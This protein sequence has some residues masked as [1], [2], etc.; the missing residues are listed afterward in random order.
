[1][2]AVLDFT[3]FTFSAE[4]IRAVNELVFD[5]VLKSPD[6]QSILTFYPGIVYDKEIGFIGRGGLVG[7]AAEGCDPAAQA[8]AIS[9]RKVKWT[10]KQWAIRIEQCAKDLESTA[11]VYAMKLGVMYDDFTSSDYMNIVIEV[12]SQSMKEFIVRFAF[13]NDTDADTFAN[14]G[15]L[16]NGIDIEYFTINDG[17]FKQA[18]TQVTANAA[19]RVTI[20]ENAGAN[21][22][23]QKLT[24][25]NVKDVY[26]PALVDGADDR[27]TQLANRAILCTNSFYKAYKASLRGIE[28]ESSF[29]LLQNGTKTLTFD[30]ELLIPIPIWDDIISSYYNNGTKKVNP[31]R[32]LYTS[33]DLLALG[34]DTESSFSD[35]DVFY[36][37]KSKK[38]IIDAEGKADAKILNPKLFMLAI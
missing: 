6:I 15:E 21:Y 24:P 22:A 27:I 2:A 38:N 4:E 33:K 17:L 10:P 3:K 25:A 14:G 32:A 8:W 31:H 26:L 7:K 34:V 18:L 11:A 1:M 19:Q 12:L 36:D 29:T 28:L 37:K 35:F 20:S 23:A 16:K 30:G 5:E 13:F 9:T